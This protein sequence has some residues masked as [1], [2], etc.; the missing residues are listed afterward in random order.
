ML[1][2]EVRI[3][4]RS[5]DYINLQGNIG[6]TML[7]RNCICSDSATAIKALRLGP[8]GLYRTSV[9]LSCFLSLVWQKNTI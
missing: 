7:Y 2:L 5:S 1:L 3:E 6:T 8:K 9:E 4:N